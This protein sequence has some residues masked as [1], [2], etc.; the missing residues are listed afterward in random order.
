MKVA[1]K[2]LMMGAAMGL[3]ALWMLHGQL[4]NEAS[5]V[6]PVAFIGAHL[7]LAFVLIA[8]AAFATRLSPGI[9]AWINR[10]HRPTTSHLV[11]MLGSALVVAAAVHLVLHG[12]SI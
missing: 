12:I 9:Q 2:P 11:S 10:I 5:I 8:A 7:L 3:M 6:G 1:Y 4:R